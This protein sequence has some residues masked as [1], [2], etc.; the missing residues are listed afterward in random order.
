MAK[1]LYIEFAD[2]EGGSLHLTLLAPS[3]HSGDG[4]R[5]ALLTVRGKDNEMNAAELEKLGKAC[6]RYA[7]D[8][9]EKG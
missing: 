1:N 3:E 4:P 7:K 6:L 5:T 9:R 8:I 2:D